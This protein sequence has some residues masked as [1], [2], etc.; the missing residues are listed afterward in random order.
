MRVLVT[1][2]LFKRT[3]LEKSLSM[4]Y[5][6]DLLIKIQ[7]NSYIPFLVAYFGKM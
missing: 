3:N 6:F 7:T 4:A 2:T 5:K 1:Y